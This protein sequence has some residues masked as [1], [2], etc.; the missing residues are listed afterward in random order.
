[1]TYQSSTFLKQIYYAS[2]KSQASFCLACLQWGEK[3]KRC[4]W[5]FTVY[6]ILAVLCSSSPGKTE[7]PS[8]YIV[9][10]AQ[11]AVNKIEKTW[12]YLF[13]SADPTGCAWDYYT[14]L[15][16]ATMEYRSYVH[17]GSMSV[18]SI[19][20]WDSAKALVWIVSTCSSVLVLLT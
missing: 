16:D 9:L 14:Y 20:Y 5:P 13:C 8:T 11:H 3:K 19:G 6:N 1:M 4:V 18:F 12:L 7:T 10:W 15:Q 2:Q 17:W